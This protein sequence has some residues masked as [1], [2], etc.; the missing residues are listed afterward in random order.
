M[1]FSIFILLPCYV[2][3]LIAP[4]LT[5]YDGDADHT[6]TSAS[7]RI[8]N[9]SQSDHIQLNTSV[10]PRLGVSFEDSYTLIQ[11]DANTAEY[12]RMLRT[13]TYN[14]VT[15]E[16]DKFQQTIRIEVKG[17][18]SLVTCL[19]S[20]I[21]IE[22]NDNVP[23]LDLNPLEVSIMSCFII[24]ATF[25]FIYLYYIY[26]LCCSSSSLVQ[27][28]QLTLPTNLLY[29]NLLISLQMVF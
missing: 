28:W 5:L 11:G 10:V 8:E 20:I 4:F 1:D 15:A 2:G 22:D 26:L 29:L 16:P 7:V 21:L 27:M 13:L 17:I 3:I 24:Y 25:D 9:Y 14:I 18:N 12:S 6:I 19:I 23:I